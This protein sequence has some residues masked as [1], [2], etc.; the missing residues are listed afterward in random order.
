MSS[1][2][3]CHSDLIRSENIFAIGEG[4]F[5]LV[6][7]LLFVRLLSSSSWFYYYSCKPFWPVTVAYTSGRHIAIICTY[8]VYWFAYIYLHSSNIC[9]YNGSNDTLSSQLVALWR[10]PFANFLLSLMSISDN[11]Q[12]IY[13]LCIGKVSSKAL[14]QTL[15]YF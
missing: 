9:L 12:N 8:F 6:H 11:K 4:N 2:F 15:L 13:L 10:T 5:H 14:L 3:F 7:S 1:L